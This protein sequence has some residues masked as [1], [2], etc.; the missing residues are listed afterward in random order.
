MRF[1][2]IRIVIKLAT[3]EG[4]LLAFAEVERDHLVRPAASYEQYAP[5]PFNGVCYAIARLLDA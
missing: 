4:R 2:Q 3:G 1:H 5:A